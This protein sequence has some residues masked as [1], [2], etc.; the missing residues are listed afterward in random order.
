MSTIVTGHFQQQAAARKAL[1]SLAAAG[2]PVDQLASFFV[3][4]AGQHDLTPI[5]G[6]EQASPGLEHAGGGAAAGATIGGAIGIATGLA[7]VAAL[8]PGA[9]IAAAGVGAYVGSFIGAVGNMPDTPPESPAQ[10]DSHRQSGMQ[11]AA[12]APSV[13]QQEDA[14]RILRQCGATD[15]EQPEGTIV[16]GDWSDFDPLSSLQRV[17]A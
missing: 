11:V 4:P 10:A 1:D 3:S 14:I 5:G 8:G 16:A 6:D 7:A 13:A 9:V 12:V 2:F 17:R 15:I